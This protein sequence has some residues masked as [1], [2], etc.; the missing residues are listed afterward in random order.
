MYTNYNP[1]YLSSTNHPLV[2]SALIHNEGVSSHV[3][4]MQ[5]MMDHME[6]ALEEASA[7]LISTQ[8]WQNPMGTTDNMNK[9]TR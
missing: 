6:T 3:E 2:S 9:N 4:A 1:F 7:N 5:M 8:C